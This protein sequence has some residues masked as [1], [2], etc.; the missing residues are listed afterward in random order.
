MFNYSILWNIEW[1]VKERIKTSGSNTLV[2]TGKPN[3][4]LLDLL[5]D[6]FLG[7]NYISLH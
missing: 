2:T 6:I 1:A 4:L 7:I 3:Y 5:S